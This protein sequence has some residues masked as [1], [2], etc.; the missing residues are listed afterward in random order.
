MIE[1]K[2]VPIGAHCWALMNDKLLV[3]LKRASNGVTCEGYEVCGAWE[4]G[5]R[6]E[7][8]DIIEIIKK[9]VGHKH[10]ELS[11]G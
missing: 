6:P 5:V 4:C 11:Y 10:T 7:E 1:N 3:V 2:E 8:I 9:P